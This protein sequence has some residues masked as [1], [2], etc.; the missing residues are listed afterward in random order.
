[1]FSTFTSN[2]LSQH[3]QIAMTEADVS[4]GLYGVLPLNQSRERPQC[5][6]SKLSELTRA[7]VGQKVYVRARLH[8]S[9]SKGNTCRVVVRCF[10][11]GCSFF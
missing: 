5:K 1:M 6:V 10:L 2:V 4:D 9:R 11:L 7:L 3:V 8:T